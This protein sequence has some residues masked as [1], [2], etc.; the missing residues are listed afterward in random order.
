MITAK[1]PL[2]NAVSDGFEELVRNK[3]KHIKILV[4]PTQ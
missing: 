4:D 1:V 2:S 3:D